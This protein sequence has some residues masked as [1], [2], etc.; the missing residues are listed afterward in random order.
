[1]PSCFHFFPLSAGPTNYISE[2]PSQNKLISKVYPTPEVMAQ[3]IRRKDTRM[4]IS[5][6]GQT[7]GSRENRNP[8]PDQRHPPTP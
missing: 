3:T 7:T 1:M 8:N 2:G 6:M 5:Y 4:E